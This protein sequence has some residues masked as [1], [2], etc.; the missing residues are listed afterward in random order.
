MAF[1][2]PSP[3]ELKARRLEREASAAKEQANR[4]T[5]ERVMV[6]GLLI[7]FGIV[8]LGVG[9]WFLVLAPNQDVTGLR[10]V[11]NLQ[12]LYIRQ[13]AAIV[14]AIFFATGLLLRNGP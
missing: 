4:N 5:A 14:D 3:E 9:L 6:A 11:V 10:T 2:A 1:K 7:V 8:L 12:R 13:S